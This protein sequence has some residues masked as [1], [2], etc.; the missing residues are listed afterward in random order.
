MTKKAQVKAQGQR[1]RTDNAGPT[2]ITSGIG[3]L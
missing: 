3:G 2:A 1:T